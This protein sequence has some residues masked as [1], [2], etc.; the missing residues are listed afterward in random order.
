MNYKIEEYEIKS[1][2]EPMVEY[3]DGIHNPITYNIIGAAMEV[4]K[5]LG[6]GFLEAVYKDCLSIEFEKRELAFEKEKKF[7]IHYKGIKISHFYYADFIIENKV[8]LEIKS[9]PLLIEE[10]MKQIINYLAVSK[11]KVGLLINFGES[12][13]KY[14][15]VILT[16]E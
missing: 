9:Q 14:K 1:V 5:T 13:L 3:G 7:D 11:C 10:S 4:H 15:R 6:K 16:Q 8:V 12:S 2:A